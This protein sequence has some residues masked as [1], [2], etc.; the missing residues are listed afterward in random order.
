[1]YDQYSDQVVLITGAASGFGALLAQQ[2]A[3]QGAKL[4][5]GDRNIAGLNAVVEPLQQAGIQVVAQACDV[6]LEAEVQA[7]VQSAV[8]HFG[9]IDVSINNA[10]MSPPMKS[11]IDTNEAD[12][13]LS[14]AINAKG[15]F[16]GMKHQIRQMLQQGGGVILNVASIA[17][18]GAA[19]KL[20]AYSAAK[21]AVVG[22]TK[23]AAVEYANKGIRVNAI[24]PFYTTTPMVLD[25]ELNA[26]QDFLAQASP[27][28]RLAHPSEVV[29]MMLMM[30][31]KENSYL[32]G[33]AI[34][35][36]GGVTAY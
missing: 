1:M 26:K 21:H 18:L 9:R 30:C 28:K 22:L 14:F 24:C 5:L 27:M 29:A 33:Q 11:F 8:D 15:V 3:E 2:L 31:A 25:S 6:S 32:T 12:L 19:P 16:F 23:T 35:I 7:L 36:D 20:A 10:G 13:D 34:A 4:V 17:G